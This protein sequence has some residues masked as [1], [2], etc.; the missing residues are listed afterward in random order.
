M[1]EQEL[2]RLAI[3]EDIGIPL[4]AERRKVFNE[5]NA[6][7]Y[8]GAVK[9]EPVEGCFCGSRDFHLLSRYDNC[10]NRS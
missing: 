5:F 9:T 3:F 2:K 10:M 6:M 1:G 7:V 4:N 8:G